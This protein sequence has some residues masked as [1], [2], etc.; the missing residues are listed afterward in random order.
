VKTS[1]LPD[2]IEVEDYLK[3]LYPNMQ[4][5]VYAVDGGFDLRWKINGKDEQ[6]NVRIPVPRMW[7]IQVAIA[8]IG[9]RSRTT[10]CG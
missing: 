7:R 4:I 1:L 6:K 5:K 3:K 2:Q 9:R 10:C 8:V